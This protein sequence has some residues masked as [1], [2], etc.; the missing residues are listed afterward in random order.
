MHRPDDPRDSCGPCGARPRDG[1]RAL[2]ADR[3]RTSPPPNPVMF[4]RAHV[5]G[6]HSKRRQG[7]CQPEPLATNREPHHVQHF[8]DTFRIRQ[9]FTSLEI[10]FP[11]HDQCACM[12]RSVLAA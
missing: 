5:E 7:L 8:S 10:I 9:E 1:R 4:D 11:P 12:S 6:T 3:L 2:D